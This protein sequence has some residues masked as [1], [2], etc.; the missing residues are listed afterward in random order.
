MSNQS[1]PTPPIDTS[2]QRVDG[3]DLP[4]LPEVV[5]RANERYPNE[6]IAECVRAYAAAEIERLLDILKARE[7][8]ID[9]HSA[10]VYEATA[11]IDQLR[12]ERDALKEDAERYRWLRFAD[13]WPCAFASSDAPE[14]LIGVE[15]DAAIDAARKS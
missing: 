1:N 8:E 14:P 9:T 3:I 10:A 13:R 6:G 12:A 15:L 7:D 11:I 5:A 4:P 2:A